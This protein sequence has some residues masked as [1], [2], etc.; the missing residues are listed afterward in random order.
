MFVI[1]LEEEEEDLAETAKLLVHEAF[2]ECDL[3]Q[4]CII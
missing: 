1:V 4:V 2:E 3:E